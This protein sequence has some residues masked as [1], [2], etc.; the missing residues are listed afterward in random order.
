MSNKVKIQIR[1][2]KFGISI[3]QDL[4]KYRTDIFIINLYVKMRRQN[5]Y[6]AGGVL[7]WIGQ[8]LL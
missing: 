1:L 7:G 2:L 4:D 8:I 6:G 3:S 5:R